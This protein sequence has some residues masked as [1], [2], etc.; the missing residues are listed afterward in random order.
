MTEPV[1]YK[2]HLNLEGNAI[3]SPEWEAVQPVKPPQ[4][5]G[6]EATEFN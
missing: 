3:G 4:C 6:G 1:P 2:E 5:C